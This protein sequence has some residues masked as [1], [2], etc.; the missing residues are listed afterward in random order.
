MLMWR[1][2]ILLGG[3]VHVECE[4]PR[5][6]LLPSILSLSCR[7]PPLLDEIVK[8]FISYI[9]RCL[10]SVSEVIKFVTSCGITVD[11]KAFSIGS[12][13]LFCSSKFDFRTSD[14]YVLSPH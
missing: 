10:S 5:N 7:S 14:I 12:S 13:T 11:Q 9:L 2:Y 1:K 8:M 4:F 3:L 6:I